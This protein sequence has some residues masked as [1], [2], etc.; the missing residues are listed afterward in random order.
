MRG[1]YPLQ[2]ESTEEKGLSS[3]RAG[4]AQPQLCTK[5]QVLWVSLVGKLG[6]TICK[7]HLAW[8]PEKHNKALSL[9]ERTLLSKNQIETW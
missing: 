5:P 7:S 2:G 8:D 6:G 4:A 3:A 9:Q 1:P